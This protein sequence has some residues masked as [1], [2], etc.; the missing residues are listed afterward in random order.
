MDVSG[1]PP[2]SRRNEDEGVVR[3]TDQVAA[4]SDLSGVARRS[5]MR[6]QEDEGFVPKSVGDLESVVDVCDSGGS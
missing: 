4:R 2:S 3:N 5:E 1:P 6:V